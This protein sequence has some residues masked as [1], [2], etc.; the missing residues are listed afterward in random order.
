MTDK[1]AAIQ[2]MEA[3]GAYNRSSRV[4]AAGLLPAVALLEQAAK[5]VPLAPHEAIVVAD[6][7]SSAGHNSLLPM[8]VAV[9]EIRRRVGLDQAVSVVH[10]DI[11]END[12]TALFQT[13]R[14]DPES[15]LRKHRGV[16]ASAIGRSFYEQ[17][18][19]SNTVTLGWSSWAI[20]WLRRIPT[21]IPDQVQ[22]AYSRDPEARTAYARQAAEDWRTFLINRSNELRDG[23]R[24]VVLTMALD[25]H[26]AFGYDA[27]L[28]AIYDTLVDMANDGVI[29]AAELRR[30][31]IPTVARSKEDMAAPFIDGGRFACLTIEHLQV[32]SGEDRIWL[33]Y[34]AS[35]DAAAFA[36]AWAA[37]ARASVSPTL[38]AALDGGPAGPRAAEFVDL[39]EAG[40]KQRLAQSPS[41]MSIPLAT[42]S[43]LKESD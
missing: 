34:E 18:M 31:A 29:Q 13:L 11:P 35:G 5:V 36:A 25:A 42:A 3:H 4:Q 27:L 15:Y 20:Q 14:D 24:L 39:L 38:A 26:G 1:S 19:P 9:T 33:E 41:R 21:A 17:L 30:M 43:L 22:V 23:G 16:Y 32:F 28:N 7:G 40:V 8:A 37:F 12:F 2:P 6:Y 10:T